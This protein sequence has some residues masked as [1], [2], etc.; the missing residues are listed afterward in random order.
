MPR[1]VAFV[2]AVFAVL[3]GVAGIG[4]ATYA[5]AN[6]RPTQQPGNLECDNNGSMASD[7]VCVAWMDSGRRTAFGRDLAAI[8]LL[9][10]ASL[11]LAALASGLFRGTRSAPA[12]SP[13]T[14]HGP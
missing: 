7:P 10:V 13:S 12:P 6:P 3:A 2:V 4:L 1:R 14:T 9:I 11:V 8:L 5:V